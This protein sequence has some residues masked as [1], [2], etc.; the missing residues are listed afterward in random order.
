MKYINL[1][2]CLVLCFSCNVS[3]E[4]IKVFDS[5]ILKEITSEDMEIPSRF[6]F[7]FFVRCNAHE[8][9]SLKI[10]QLRTIYKNNNKGISLREYLE[11]LL[12]QEKYL[13][14]EN[15][16]DCFTLEK[17]V[18]DNYRS[19][20]FNDFMLLYCQNEEG[21]YRFRNDLSNL[22]IKTVSYYL[23]LNNYYVSFDDIIGFY[24]VRN[25]SMLH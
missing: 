3:G 12:N 7:D 24:Y 17:T 10:E 16:E 15:F 5:I 9:A 14:K 6:T 8:V 18:T 13:E 2:I 23:F 1:F 22:T 25:S 20:S 11:P 4:K 21:I 19:R